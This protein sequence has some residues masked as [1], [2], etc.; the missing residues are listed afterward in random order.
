MNDE[1]HLREEL[2]DGIE[3]DG[4]YAP[5][6]TNWEIV[7]I[8]LMYSDRHIQ[9]VGI[10]FAVFVTTEVILWLL[11]ILLETC[12]SLSDT[13][14]ALITDE[15]SAFIPAVDQFRDPFYHVLCAMHKEGTL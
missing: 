14:W 5:L 12:P 8:T 13:W 1:R 11:G 3:I 15:D 4:T 2:G 6:K 7:P 9:C 10:M